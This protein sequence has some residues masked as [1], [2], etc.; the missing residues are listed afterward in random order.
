MINDQQQPLVSVIVPVYGVEQ[1]LDRCVE[2]IVT[3][4]YCNL[5]I[6]LVDDGSPDTCPAKCDAW[7]DEDDRIRVV[8]KEN[9]G[10]GSARNAGLSIMSG[11]FVVFVDSDDY[12]EA[13]MVSTMLR[14]ALDTDA[15]MVV[16]GTRKVHCK[17]GQYTEVSVNTLVLPVTISNSDVQQHF[18]ELFLHSYCIP[19]WNKMYSRTFLNEHGARYDETVEVGE[20]TLFNVP[21]YLTVERLACVPEPLYNY[22]SR[23]G[24]LCNRFKPTW[25]RDRRLLFQ[26]VEPLMQQW[27]NEYV[28][29]FANEFIYQTG[30]ILSFLYEDENPQTKAIRRKIIR[31][32]AHDFVVAQALKSFAPTNRRN[33]LT[34]KVLASRQPVLLALYG[35]TV[36]AIKRV[37]AGMEQ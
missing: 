13:D 28:N 15:Q 18:A 29:L 16:C 4:T 25:F 32:I 37:K 35:W 17:D 26:R 27:G 30:V 34:S 11:M 3:Q 20:D 31:D 21:L 5:E 23:G 1:Y 10:L 7:A 22:V 14:T 24:S 9:G 8:H 19:A 12:V 36:A 2:S 33:A 6:I